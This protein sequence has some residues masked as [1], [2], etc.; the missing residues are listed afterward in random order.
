[1]N[2]NS[3]VVNC[4]EFLIN[5]NNTIHFKLSDIGALENIPLIIYETPKGKFTFINMNKLNRILKCPLC[6]KNA[7]FLNEFT[8][9]LNCKCNRDEVILQI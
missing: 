4:S 2:T 3:F 7:V 5:A 9:K 8:L 1:M 6:G